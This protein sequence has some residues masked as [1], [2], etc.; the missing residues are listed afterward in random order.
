[1]HQLPFPCP[2]NRSNPKLH[3]L[4]VFENNA[5]AAEERR[6]RRIERSAGLIAKGA[7]VLSG[8]VF[9]VIAALAVFSNFSIWFGVPAAVVGFFNL[10][11]GFSGNT[12]EQWAQRRVAEKLTRYMT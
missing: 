9:A 4:K 12:V 8:L 7:F 10:W 1:M 11:C 5:R 2:S 3:K 6:T